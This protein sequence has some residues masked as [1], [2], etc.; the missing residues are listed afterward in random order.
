MKKQILVLILFG[1]IVSCSS[2]KCIKEYLKTEIDKNKQEGI[3][4]ILNDNKGKVNFVLE[5]YQELEFSSNKH[6]SKTFDQKDYDYLSHLIKNDSK[7]EYWTETEQKKFEFE[8]LLIGG[9]N[10]TSEI[11]D[12]EKSYNEKV[13][14]YVISNPI[15]L[16]NSKTTIFLVNKLKGIG[17][18]IEKAVIVMKK[19]NGKWEFIEKIVSQAQFD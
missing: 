8:K 11:R 14:F 17:K 16:K 7:I 1:F 3:V 4:S 5:V 15:K 10:K 13:I 6:I 9:F 12:L 2:N 19:E 18:H